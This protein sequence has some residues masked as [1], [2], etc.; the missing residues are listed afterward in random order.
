VALVIAAIS[1]TR[2]RKVASQQIEL[3]RIT[4]E[5]SAKQLEM[6]QA[7]EAALS[8]AQIDVDLEGYGSDYNFIISNVGGAE[9]RN[10]TFKIEGEDDPVVSSEYKDKIPIPSLRPGKSVQLMAALH[11]GSTFKYKVLVSWQNP[12]ASTEQDEFFLTV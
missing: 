11:S 6:L 7:R 8:K 5:L 1:L 12:D 10:V 9:A 2:T 3:E 4:A